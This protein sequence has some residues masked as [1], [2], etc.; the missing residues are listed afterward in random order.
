MDKK[1]E[2]LKDLLGGR[3]EIKFAY[4]FGSLAKG[5]AGK[6]SDIDVA[7]FVED[8]AL[9]ADYP[10]GYK[11]MLITELMKTLKTNK[12]DVVILNEAK[13]FLC[14]QVLRDGVLLACNDEAARI[15][16]W[17][18]TLHRYN[19]AKWLLGIQ[20]HYMQKRIEEGKFGR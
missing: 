15:E 14:S 17:V 16:F 6:L 18:T 5:T 13:P 12:V 3:S 9:K 1:I 4:L 11:A 10:Y 2:A 19:D 20:N 7:V 8:T